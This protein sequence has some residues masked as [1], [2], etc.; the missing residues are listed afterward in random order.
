VEWRD[1]CFARAERNERVRVVKVP[2]RAA[3]ATKQ[4]GMRALHSYFFTEEASDDYLR[5]LVVI[6]QWVRYYTKPWGP[7]GIYMF[8]IPRR[9]SQDFLENRYSD[10]KLSV[11][12]NGLTVS[13]VLP[14]VHTI[15]IAQVQT[16]SSRASKRKRNTGV[17]AAAGPDQGEG[18]QQ[19]RSVKSRFVPLEELKLIIAERQLNREVELNAS[20]Y[21][22]AAQN[23]ICSGCT[24]AALQITDVPVV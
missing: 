5:M 15:E 19:V 24:A 4:L 20:G 8:A 6:R 13:N 10:I 14:A 17:G 1:E 11:G 9:L 7:G 22:A 12:H 23:T 2:G 16:T 21:T 3:V 18:E